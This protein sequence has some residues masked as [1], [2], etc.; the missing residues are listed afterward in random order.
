MT[1]KND[2]RTCCSGFTSHKRGWSH[3]VHIYDQSILNTTKGFFYRKRSEKQRILQTAS[4]MEEAE[5]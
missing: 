2:P 5:H 4:L 1:D 3:A